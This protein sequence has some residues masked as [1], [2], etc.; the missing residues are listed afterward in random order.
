MRSLIIPPELGKVTA[1]TT[2][3]GGNPMKIKTLDQLIAVLTAMKGNITTYQAAVGATAADILFISN[4]LANLDYLR[5]YAEAVDAFKKGVFQMKQTAFEG[6]VNEVIGPFPVVAAGASPT[7]LEAGYLERTQI[8]IRR[9]KLGPGYNHDIGVALG[10]Q[11]SD[12]SSQIPDPATVK[13]TVEAFAAQTGYVASVVVGNR[14]GSDM[15]EVQ[16]SPTSA[17]HWA[18]VKTATGK[19]TDVTFTP[20]TPGQPQQFQIRIQLKRNNQNYGQLSDI[21]SVTVNP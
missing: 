8:L 21:I 7:P 11:S 10:F 6:D 9:F 3:Q 17:P 20:A 15:W 19:S 2:F 18:V 4:A 16:A 5:D 13:P 14:T 1:T 12:P